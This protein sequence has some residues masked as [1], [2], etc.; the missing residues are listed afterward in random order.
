MSVHRQTP[1]PRGPAHG[2]LLVTEAVAE[3]TRRYLQRS[4]G[5]A[6]RRHEGIVLWAGRSVGLDTAVA[7][8]V[9]VVADHGRGFVHVAAA[10]VGAA[11]RAARAHGLAVLAQ[12]HSHPGSDTRHSDGDDQLVLMPYEGMFSLVVGR[13]GD[14]A[15][16]PAHGA[17]LHQFQDGRWV[18][19]D[20]VDAAFLVIPAVIV[21]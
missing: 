6:G 3:Q 13:Y 17:G 10:A 2:R 20:P 9:A 15:L 14:G 12:V 5:A 21:P 18:W 11:A 1:L 16:H 8:A 19:I 4:T 7:A